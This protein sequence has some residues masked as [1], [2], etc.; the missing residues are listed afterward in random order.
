MPLFCAASMII[1]IIGVRVITV[2]LFAVS[3][4]CAV[5]ACAAS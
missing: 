5:P 2:G 1:A 3:S 4:I